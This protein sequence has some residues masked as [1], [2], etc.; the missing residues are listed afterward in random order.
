MLMRTEPLREAARPT[1]QA[2]GSQQG[3]WTRPVVIPLE[4]YRRGAEFVVHFDLPGVDPASIDLTVERNML[5]VRAERRP[6]VQE[7][8]ETVVA[9]RPYGV[10]ARQLVLGD[11]LDTEHI[12]ADYAAGVLTLHIP[13]AERAKSRK[14]EVSATTAHQTTA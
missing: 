9:E 2:F 8:A 1:Q 3:S 12:E 10:F 6:A 11:A 13:V 7:Q 5:T 14:I 4:A